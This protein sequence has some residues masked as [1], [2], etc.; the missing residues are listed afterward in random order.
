MTMSKSS[1]TRRLTILYLIALTSIALLSVAGQAVF[2]W[3]IQQ[4]KH[5]TLVISAANRQMIFGQQISKDALF[6]AYSS[7]SSARTKTQQELQAVF[8]IWKQTFTGLQHGD[9]KLGLSGENSTTV[10]TLYRSIQPD[11]IAINQAT[12]DILSSAS[13]TKNRNSSAA[14]NDIKIILA[15][16]NTFSSGMNAIV[17]RY[18]SEAEARAST[19]R[20]IELALLFITLTVL[21]GEALLV[22]RPATSALQRTMNEIFALKQSIAQQKQELGSGIDKLLKT[23]VA[24]AAGDFHARWQITYNLN[25][26]LARFNSLLQI[27]ASVGKFQKDAQPKPKPIIPA[28]LQTAPVQLQTA[29]VVDN[30]EQIQRDMQ[31]LAAVIREAKTKKHPVPIVG[32]STTIAPLYQELGGNYISSSPPSEKKFKQQKR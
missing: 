11:F 20:V 14:Q 8:A 31:R 21:T 23:N 28:Q 6:L 3:A 30:C 13:N 17:G 29:N 16:E 25:N 24:I 1:P 9:T 2:Q 15:R 18:Q 27:E 32:S 4:Q 22:F 12:Q 26:L 10:Q 5:D 19:I 7:D